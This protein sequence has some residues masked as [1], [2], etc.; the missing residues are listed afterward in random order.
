MLKEKLA[1]NTAVRLYFAIMLVALGYH[2]L[3]LAQ[4]VDYKNAWGGRLQSTE[5]MYAFEIFSILLQIVFAAIIYA[6][7]YTR[8]KNTIY[9]ITKVLTFIIA[10]IFLL[11]TVGNLFAIQLFE[12][13]VF[14]PLTLIASIV[15]LRIA[16]E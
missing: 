14:T 7:A 8:K 5:Q 16:I 4:V 10:L 6:K 1:L 3:I 13:V 12:R 9:K 15:T 11:N 2:A